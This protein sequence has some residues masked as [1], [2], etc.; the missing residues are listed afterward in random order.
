MTMPPRRASLAISATLIGALAGV[1][2]TAG[3]ADAAPGWTVNCTALNQRFVH[4]LGKVSAVD[5]TSGTPVTTFFR[6]N[7]KFKKAMSYNRGLDADK[8]RIACEQ[9]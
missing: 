6:S 9:A 8:D 2:A 7:K 5:S 1:A 3:S 4:G